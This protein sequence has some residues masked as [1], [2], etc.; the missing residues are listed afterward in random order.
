MNFQS[1]SPNIRLVNNSMYMVY[2]Y[3]LKLYNRKCL[4]VLTLIMLA[5]KGCYIKENSVVVKEKGQS[6]AAVAT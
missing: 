1:E 4:H 5:H 6:E 2:K 3:A